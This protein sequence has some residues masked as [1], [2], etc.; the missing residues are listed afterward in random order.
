MTAVF[1]VLSMASSAMAAKTLEYDIL[2][3]GEP[4]GKEVV[5]LQDKGGTTEVDVV[6]N[7]RVNVLFLNFVYDHQRKEIWKNGRMVFMDAKTNDDGDHHAYVLDAQDDNIAL[8]V[9]GKQVH[10]EKGALPLT[11]WSKAVLD[12]TVLL[13]VIDAQP[14]K[15]KISALG[16]NHFKIDGDVNR[17]LWFADDGYLQKAAF[18]RKGF[19]I[20]FV[21]K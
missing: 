7:T 20:E 19:L 15:V 11:L 9:D 10:A 2:K 1:C 14:Y 8:E 6:T 13:S 17:E 12:K 3:E 21:R 4:I 16:D 5:T 18:K